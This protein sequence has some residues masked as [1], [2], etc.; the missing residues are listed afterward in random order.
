MRYHDFTLTIAADEI[1]LVTQVDGQRERTRCKFTYDPVMLLCVQ[2]L[3]YWLNY[4]LERFA[5]TTGLDKPCELADLQA[6]GWLL[7]ELL[8]RDSTIREPF[9]K[10]YE[11]FANA[12][13]SEKACLDERADE[14]APEL[15]LR[16]HLILDGAPESLATL[17]WEFLFVPI[18]GDVEKG[19]FFSGERTE[20]ILTRYSP[21]KKLEDELKPQRGAL[22]ILVIYASPSGLD[23]VDPEEVDKLLQ[24]IDDIGHLSHIVMQRLANPS[25]NEV[26]KAIDETRPHIVHYIGHG[27]ADKLALC[28]DTEDPDFIL[29][30]PK[31]RAQLR[32]ISGKQ[33]KGLFSNHRPRLV[34]LHACKG[35]A[36]QSLQSLNSTARDL[37][38]AK[39]PAVVAMQYNISNDDAG[40]FAREFYMQLGQGQSIDEAVKAGR[41]VLGTRWPPWEHPRFGTPVLYLL[42]RNAIV[43]MPPKE[44]QSEGGKTDS[45]ANARPGSAGGATAAVAV[46]SSAAAPVRPAELVGMD[47]TAAFP[48]PKDAAT[49]AVRGA[50]AP[51]S[52]NDNSLPV[53]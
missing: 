24:Q 11:N 7:H 23:I 29:T 39:I 48:S 4:S 49:A 37:V 44:E 15:R 12:Y 26:K 17:P 3:N 2:R 16:L 38:N 10:A 51:N 52:T 43:T 33:F 36:H 1:S 14:S 46:A 22:K 31:D 21:D 53:G 45:H 18:G 9:Y 32:W 47:D 34:F 20:L 8:F 13:S 42:C 19:F 25:Y 50:A 35:A 27:E 6:I 5:S 40:R 41:V 28:K 30:E